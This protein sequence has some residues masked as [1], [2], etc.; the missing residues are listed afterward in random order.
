MLLLRRRRALAWIDRVRLALIPLALLAASASPARAESKPRLPLLSNEEAWNRL[1]GAPKS[2]EPLPAWARM[3]AGRL[4]LTTA[5][6]LELDAMHRTGDRLDARLR[7][8]VRWA[9]ADANGCAYAKAAALADLRRAAVSDA[10][11]RAVATSPERLPALDRAAVGFARKMM[12]EAH[13]VTDAEFKHLLEVAGEERVVA[14][15]ALLAHASFQDRV[16]LALD[17]PTDPAGPPP[18]LAVRFNLPKPKA[19]AGSPPKAKGPPLPPAETP[20]AGDW[21]NLQQELDRQRARPGRIRVPSRE[22]AVA[23]IGKKHPGAWQMDI[24]W[25]RVCYGYQPEL[26]EAWFSC[27]SAFR[28]ETTWDPVFSQS[29]FWVVTRSLKCFY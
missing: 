14:L 27:V 29:I 22:E 25:S 6:M 16:L 17:A 12:R 7:G 8:L 18:P 19:P 4:P 13:A 15:V 2:A 3:L 9:A 21:L 20:P 23:R 10:D 5:R 26:T 28:Q 1:P 11:L 24:L